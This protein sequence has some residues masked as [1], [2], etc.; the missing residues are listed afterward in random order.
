VN[1]ENVLVVPTVGI[2]PFL[3]GSFS[4]ANLDRSLDYILASYSFR[5][6]AVVEED[7]S[8]KQII[9]YVIVR[10]DASYLL[11]RRTNRQTES[12]LHG[13]Y[14]LGIG[15]HI[16][17]SERCAAG[18][19]ILNAGLERELA[20]EVKLLGRRRAMDLVGL[21]S[22]DSTAVGQV[23]LGL[24][25]LLETDTPE[26]AVQ[27]PE[28]MTAE[29]APVELLRQRLPQMETWSQLVFEHVVAP[30]GVQQNRETIH[31]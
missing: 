17:D 11:I 30:T 5:S 27:E 2:K 19:N 1:Q 12:R 7:P 4:S 13:K 20:E 26:Y 28:L 22:D 18:Q 25:Y 24:V 10:H 8:F 31:A 9:P 21:I 3:S 16:N 6:R 29:W 14:S 23:H 15:G